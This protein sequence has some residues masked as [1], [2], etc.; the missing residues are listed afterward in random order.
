MTD[1]TA[2]ESGATPRVSVIVPV[3]NEAGNVA[4]LIGEIARAMAPLAP[5]EIVYV[6]DG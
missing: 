2:P 1:A 3:R 4:P 6:N 5:F